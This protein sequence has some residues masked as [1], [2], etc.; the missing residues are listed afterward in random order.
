MRDATKY[1]HSPKNQVSNEQFFRQ[2]L[3]PT[4]PQPMANFP[5]FRWRMSNSVRFPVFPEKW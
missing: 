3:L 1:Q 4:I 2:Y 5:T